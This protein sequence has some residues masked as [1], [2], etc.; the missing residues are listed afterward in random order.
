M[1][2]AY[3]SQVH[4][5]PQDSDWLSQSIGNAQMALALSDANQ[6]LKAL[7]ESVDILKTCLREHYECGDSWYSCP[8]SKEGCSNDG[9]NYCNCGAEQH[10]EK[11]NKAI[12]LI[13][14]MLDP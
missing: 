2:L 14:S 4:P 10:N 9:L 11:V 8:K 6:H 12:S 13:Y 5:L 1:N 7:R 3:F